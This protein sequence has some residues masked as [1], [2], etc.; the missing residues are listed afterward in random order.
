MLIY[1]CA[2]FDY[3]THCCLLDGMFHSAF[4]YYCRWI[5][6]DTLHPLRS[7]VGQTSPA[8]AGGM[9]YLHVPRAVLDCS[10]AFHGEMVAV[11]LFYFHLFFFV[12][13]SY[14]KAVGPRIGGQGARRVKSETD[15]HVS[16]KRR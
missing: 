3:G 6:L 14:S 1:R 4:A 10:L 13:A 9:F 2:R 5:Q 8:S 7:V 11:G 16:L 12:R 15:I